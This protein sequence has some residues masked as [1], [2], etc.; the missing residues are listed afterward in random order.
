MASS[1]FMLD[2]FQRHFDKILNI[3][4]KAV[5]NILEIDIMYA[6]DLVVIVLVVLISSSSFTYVLPML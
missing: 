2:T 1:M 6:D 4:D 5:G 3:Y